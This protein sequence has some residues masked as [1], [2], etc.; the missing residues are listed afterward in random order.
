MTTKENYETKLPVISAIADDRIKTPIIPVHVYV[1]EAGD[2]FKCCLK[3][4]AA[5]V[6]KGMHWEMVLDLP[7]RTGAL[8][9]AET[10]WGDERCKREPWA[11]Q[12]PEAYKLRDELL[13]ELRFAYRE[14]VEL[15]ARL[16]L[17]SGGNGHADMIQDL[18]DL[19]KLGKNNPA[20]LE[21]VNFDMTRL[22][23]A[24]VLVD[25]CSPLYSDAKLER[26]RSGE[27]KRIRDQAYT[28]LKEAVDEIRRYGRHIFR[29]DEERK[30]GYR[31]EHLKRKNVKKASGSASEETGDN[32]VVPLDI[33]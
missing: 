20:P 12:L 24:V 26:S 29:H 18:N 19:G 3:D 30:K 27:A 9:E 4:E 17:V 21:Q 28:H 16:K 6:G 10:Y 33:E 31:S 23:R 13:Q 2:L 15:V 11:D 14:D 8:R 5:L 7:V 22:D 25:E 32:I 1:Q